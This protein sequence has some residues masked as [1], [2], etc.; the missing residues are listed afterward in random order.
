MNKTIT[1][2][3]VFTP[4]KSPV[5]RQI[6]GNRTQGLLPLLVGYPAN[7]NTFALPQPPN[8][9]AVPMRNT[10]M[11]RDLFSPPGAAPLTRAPTF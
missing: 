2:G 8:H 11:R 9:D 7:L 10:G 4:P 3:I 6:R 5:F 1:D